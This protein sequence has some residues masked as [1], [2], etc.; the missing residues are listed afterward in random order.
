MLLIIEEEDCG[1]DELQGRRQADKALCGGVGRDVEEL[2]LRLGLRPP[3]V[4]RYAL[5]VLVLIVPAHAEEA[6]VGRGGVA[7]RAAIARV[8]AAASPVTGLRV[9]CCALCP[10]SSVCS[11][12]LCLC[13]SVSLSLC[14][15]LPLSLDG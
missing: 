15:S 5:H 2:V 8:A 6:L 12:S 4:P 14:V 7:E 13:L 10:V 3:H 11:L 9:G 1:E